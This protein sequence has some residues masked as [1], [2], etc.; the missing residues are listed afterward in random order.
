MI[1]Y[2]DFGGLWTNSN[3]E[4]HWRRWL[5][6]KSFTTL[7]V[8]GNHENHI[9]LNE[10]YPEVEFHG[11]HAHKISDSVYHLMRGQIFTIG[12]N[13]IFTMGGAESHDKE[14]RIE[15]FSW[16]AEEMPST[17][18]YRE[19]LTNLEANNMEVDYIISHCAPESIQAKISVFHK[20]KV[21]PNNKLTEFFEELKR[22]V[23]YKH[24][25]FGHYHLSKSIDQKHTCLYHYIIK[26]GDTLFTFDL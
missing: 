16:W 17:E 15:G 12:G 18:D 10:D 3:E 11:G 13:R 6:N 25:Y 26:L 7:F 8:D 20:L 1:V 5:D 23:K 4:K 19:A 24:W 14:H 22:L 21:Y 2:G 9:M